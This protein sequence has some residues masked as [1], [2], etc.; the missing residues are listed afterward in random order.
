MRKVIIVLQIAL[1]AGLLLSCENQVQTPE[2]DV[3]AA[4][5]KTTVVSDDGESELDAYKV[6]FKFT[7]APDNIVFYSGEDG[8]DYRYRDR[9]TRV[10]TPYVSFK[11]SYV[12]GMPN[13][14]RVLVSNDFKPEYEYLAGTPTTTV[15]TKWG[16]QEA[17]WTDITDRFSIPGN[18]LVGEAQYSGEAIL[19][20]FHGN[21][22]L[23]IAF[24]F[25]G[26]EGET[27]LP[28][29]WSFSDFNI[30]NVLQDGTSE[31]YISNGIGSSWK[32]VD[33]GA[34]VQCSRGSGSASLSASTDP[35]V[36]TYLISAPY[37]P[38]NIQS[39][40]GM[41]IKSIDENLYE[42]THTYIDPQEESVYVAFVATNSLYGKSIS[43]VRAFELKFE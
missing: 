20:E 4:I 12:G 35:N 38:S 24:Q 36:N 41:A 39:D 11:S 18:K 3:S 5:E 27:A 8:A 33:F 21:M 28:G 15:Y 40:T 9:Y 10:V 29:L 32:S 34:P 23:F 25:K 22:P 7:G 2:F 1:A 26:S 17:T 31:S 14:L 42:Y 19:S 16:V 37:Y 30:R 13:T 43:I 6:T